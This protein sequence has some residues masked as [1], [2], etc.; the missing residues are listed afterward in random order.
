[1]KDNLISPVSEFVGAHL[2]VIGG[3]GSCVV[4]D[5]A[6]LVVLSGADLVV[7]GGGSRVVLGQSYD[8]TCG[9]LSFILVT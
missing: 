6:D 4:L 3:G 2:V 9:P 8:W 5:G 1:M 7:L